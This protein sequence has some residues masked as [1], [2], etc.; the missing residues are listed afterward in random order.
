MKIRISVLGLLLSV[1]GFSQSIST[2]APS[3][4]ASAVTI[5]KGILQGELSAGFDVNNN[6][7]NISIQSNELPYLL[8]RYG[9]TDRW[10]LR[11]QHRTQ[12]R[13]NNGINN[14]QYVSF[15]VGAK[16]A[17]LPNGGSTNLALILNYT[18]FNGIWRAQQGDLTLAFSH[19]FSEKHS[20]GGNL[21]YARFAVTAEGF[22][23]ISRQISYPAS[24]YYS[25][26]FTENW[27]AFGEFYYQYTESSSMG[28]NVSDNSTYG[29]DFGLQFLLKENI[30][31]DWVSGFSLSNNSQ[32]HSLGFNIYFDTI[33]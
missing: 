9:L 21:G 13:R 33:K 23:I 6:G 7:Q 20:I 29:I 28:A 5:P 15:G 3:I 10:E 19:S 12:F 16:Y 31:L 27:T 14:Y 25:F 30:Q 22:G 32:F 1:T 24:A 11:T 8:T 17:I 18:P 26:N 4:S 2:E